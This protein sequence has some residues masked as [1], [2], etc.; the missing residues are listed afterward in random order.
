MQVPSLQE[1]LNTKLFLVLQNSKATCI[2][3]WFV[4]ISVLANLLVNYKAKRE[5]KRQGNVQV[6]V[7]FSFL[8]GAVFFPPPLYWPHFESPY[9]CRS[10]SAWNLQYPYCEKIQSIYCFFSEHKLYGFPQSDFNP[11]SMFETK[12]D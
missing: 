6:L 12:L 10:S 5:R 7:I 3:I 2:R 4:A 11:K 8:S 1:Y 9:S